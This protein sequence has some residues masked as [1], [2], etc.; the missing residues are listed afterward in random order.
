MP[1]TTSKTIQELK[2]KLKLIEGEIQAGNN[3][4]MLIKIYIKK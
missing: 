1:N 4:P 3:N 2:N